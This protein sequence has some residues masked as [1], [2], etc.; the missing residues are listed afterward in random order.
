[1]LVEACGHGDVVGI[2]G[3]P[4][5]PR[6]SR[7]ER[8]PFRFDRRAV[9][10]EWCGAHLV[11]LDHPELAAEHRTVVDRVRRALRS[12]NVEHAV[13]HADGIGE[14]E[15]HAADGAEIEAARADR[16]RNWTVTEEP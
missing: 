6:I 7:M 1:D 2:D 16:Q 11:A 5:P 12:G 8:E 13:A 10:L 9:D 15:P 4:G 14:A 3:D